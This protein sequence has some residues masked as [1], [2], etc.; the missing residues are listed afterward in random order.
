LKL[1]ILLTSGFESQD[2]RTALKIAEA[3]LLAGHEVGVFLMEQGVY[4]APFL[5]TLSSQGASVVWCSHNAAQ[6][7]LPSSP[8]VREGSQFDW[9]AMAAEADRVLSFG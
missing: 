9:A 4:A 5:A 2:R 8:G 6:R 1:A 7:G 3:A